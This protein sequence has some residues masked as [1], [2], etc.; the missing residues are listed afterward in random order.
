[1]IL[2]HNGQPIAPATTIRNATLKDNMG[3]LVDWFRQGIDNPSGIAITER[4]MYSLTTAWCCINGIATTLAALPLIV[5]KGSESDK[6]KQKDSTLYR[7]LHDVPDP[8]KRDITAIQF[9]RKMTQ[10]CVVGNGY[11][12]IYR[13]VS[14]EPIRLRHIDRSRVTPK[15]NADGDLI[16]EVAQPSGSG[17][18]PDR[19][20]A[21]DIF[22]L[23]GFGEA[24]MGWDIVQLF[25]RTFGLAVAQESNQAS[26]FANGS[27]LGGMFRH[28]GVMGEE[29]IKN[30]RKNFEREFGGSENAGKTIVTEEGMEYTPF[31]ANNQEA[32]QA[33][34]KSAIGVAICQ[35]FRVPPHKAQILDRATFS[36]IEQQNIEYV[37]DCLMPY[38][39][40]WEQ[41]I[42]LKLIS[43]RDQETF[44][45]HNLTG[46]LRGDSAARA[47]FYQI[48][49]NIGALTLNEVRLLENLNSIG[50][51]GDETL[52]QGNNTTTLERVINP[53]EPPKAI[54][55]PAEPKA[56]VP[57][58]DRQK[59]I[60]RNHARL[61][62][63]DLQRWLRVEADK[64]NR[65]AK[66]R[67]GFTNW[68][69]DYYEGHKRHVA[70]S[71]KPIVQSYYD[72][73]R[74]VG[75]N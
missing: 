37:Q 18:E 64:V 26:F 59:A 28:P 67:V 42:Q 58:S 57:P 33:E 12:Y 24:E 2:D 20:P 55:P 21:R 30:F 48:M 54:A 22:H 25:A 71:I 70:A 27:R 11:A 23:A 56:P 68:A 14:G 60:T 40:L 32:Q 19:F 35:I 72:S 69:N 16:Y 63:N 39:E 8:I 34:L 9:R 1:M 13:N 10:D 51:N 65:A 74:A 29:A 7:I 36:N 75:S 53:P 66:R 61:L 6:K 52:V 3:W 50:P 47:A 43:P 73:I 46:L 49:V 44:A 4:L 31:T 5:L 38:C 41:Q 45:E 62:A 17:G 15:Y